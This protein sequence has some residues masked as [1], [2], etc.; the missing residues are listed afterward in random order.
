MLA[1]QLTIKTA[2]IYS[3]AFAADGATV[4]IGSQ[5]NPVGLWDLATGNLLRVYQLAGPVW[6]LAWSSDQR[7]FLS[8]DGTLRL[9]EVDTGRCLREFDGRH[10]R[11]VAWSADQQQALSASNGTLRLTELQAGRCVRALEGHTDGIYCVAFD[12]ERTVRAVRFSR[13][14]SAS[15]GPSDGH[16]H[17]SSRRT[18]VSR[19]RCGLGG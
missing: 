8:L 19:A 5:G 12:L 6:A 9:W 1:V 15:M 4:L 17:R 7:S 18:H 14:D 13:P 16:L 10:A 2:E 11:C 3:C